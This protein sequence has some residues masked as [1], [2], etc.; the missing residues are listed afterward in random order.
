ME[1]TQ[2]LESRYCVRAYLDK[3]VESSLI[4]TIFQTARFAPSGVNTQPWQVIILKNAQ[5]KNITTQMTQAFDQGQLGSEE[6]DY[7]PE[8]WFEPFATRRKNCGLA[9]FAALSIARADTQKRQSAWRLNYEFFKAPV[10][11][12]F[13]K[14]RRLGV[15]SYLDYGM[16]LQNVMIM[17]N[18]L[19]LGTCP[20]AAIAQ[21]HQ[22][23]RETLQIPEEL[24]VVC[25][26]ALGYPDLKDPANSYRLPKLSADQF[27]RWEV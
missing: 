27:L 11:L 6:Y 1:V 4:Q 25:G 20:Q 9:R 18:S 12:I 13:L 21:Y 2:A 7:Y 14:D 5:L 26:M 16:F 24:M 3:D 10:G 19:G 15:G 8:K 17:A 23:L 22:I